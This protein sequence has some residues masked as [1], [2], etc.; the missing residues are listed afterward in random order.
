MKAIVKVSINGYGSVTP[1]PYDWDKEST[2]APEDARTIAVAA[3]AF[4]R[5]IFNTT[6]GRTTFVM[7]FRD[8]FVGE[9]RG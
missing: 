2:S 8:D 5:A 6:Y 4:A 1:P 3:V 9:I 7:T